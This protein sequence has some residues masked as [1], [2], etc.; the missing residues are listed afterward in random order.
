MRRAARITTHRLKTMTN[1]AP[2][3]T[4]EGNE[5][6]AA[7]QRLRTRHLL[8]HG[9]RLRGCHKRKSRKM[10]ASGPTG[11]VN[12]ELCETFVKPHPSYAS[13]LN[14]CLSV[15]LYVHTE[16]TQSH[17]L[18]YGLAMVYL[19]CD[20]ARAPHKYYKFPRLCVHA[21]MCVRMCR[22]TELVQS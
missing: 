10:N 5:E 3:P 22:M 17:M 15:S 21:C 9:L 20:N 14:Y 19:D 6:A 8:E 18:L 4:T 1:N 16:F 12:D 13:C 2:L 11:D 7:S